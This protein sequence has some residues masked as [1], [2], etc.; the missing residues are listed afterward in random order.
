MERSQVELAV[1]LTPNGIPLIGPI[2]IL[3]LAL[4]AYVDFKINGSGSR[5]EYLTPAGFLVIFFGLLFG[6]P[7]VM[8]S[9]AVIMAIG[10]GVGN[11]IRWTQR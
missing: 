5:W 8:V 2:A 10:V 9:G 7:A 4:G 3:L 6:R 11:Y 1:K